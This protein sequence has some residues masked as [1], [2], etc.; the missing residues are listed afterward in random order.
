MYYTGQEITQIAVRI[1]EN[2][3]AFYK[4]AAEKIKGP[5]DIRNLFLDLAEKEVV[6]I[7]VFQKMAEKFEPE[8][9]EM[10]PDESSDYV[11][12]L[13]ETHIFGKP[14]SG[15]KLARTVSTPQQALEIAYKFEID[16][17]NFYIELGKRAKT[18]SQKL[19][20]QIIEEEKDHAADIKRFM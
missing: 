13:A 8:D 19:I 7:S 9:L 12:H 3:Y 16:S 20:H 6:H 2:G 1:E 17:V 4:A 15:V 18:D 5:N 14:E 10:P 11:A